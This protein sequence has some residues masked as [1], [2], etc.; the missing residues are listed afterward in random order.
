MI[1]KIAPIF[2]L[3]ILMASFAGFGYSLW[4]ENLYLTGTID[5]TYMDVEWSVHGT[6]DTETKEVSSITAIINPENANRMTVAI[7]EA[8]PCV[9]YIAVFDI[10][11]VGPLPV[12]IHNMVLEVPENFPGTIQVCAIPEFDNPVT[13]TLVHNT[14]SYFA[15]VFDTVQ[16]DAW[17][18]DL[19]QYIDYVTYNVDLYCSYRDGLP[20]PSPL[21]DTCQWGKINWI[22]NH[23]E[24]YSQNWQDA[25]SAIWAI[26]EPGYQ[27]TAIGQQIADDAV[28]CYVPDCAAGEVMA[29][30]VRT[31]TGVGTAQWT[32]VEF[33]C[34]CVE[35]NPDTITE[36]IQLHQ[37][38]A[39]WFM[40]KVHLNNDARQDNPP[41]EAPEYRFTIT[42][43][44]HQYNECPYEMPP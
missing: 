6:C 19:Q 28:C 2:L 18:V 43:M 7:T 14:D 32:I 25:Q 31:P 41:D 33:P 40:L 20:G 12:H 37:G 22:I 42:A 39:A 4:F 13:G 1:K 38:D 9:D 27:P 35:Y 11:S 8:Y 34:C 29:V 24:A 30:L 15:W 10:H 16:Y 21:L 5:T 23:W 3:G 36:E 26:A 44:V 17:C